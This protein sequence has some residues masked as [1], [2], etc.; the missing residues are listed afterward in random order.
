MSLALAAGSDVCWLICTT[1]VPLV[2][3]VMLYAAVVYVCLVPVAAGLLPLAAVRPNPSAVPA[4][5]RAS[6]P[7]AMT[8]G[9]R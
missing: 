7:P 6:V 1:T 3:W 9:R 4:T 5:A 8:R 2:F